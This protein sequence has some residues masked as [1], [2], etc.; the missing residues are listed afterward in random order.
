MLI[1]LIS[2]S[3]GLLE[4]SE[5]VQACNGITLAVNDDLYM[6]ELQRVYFSENVI[7]LVFVPL[8]YFMSSVFCIEPFKGKVKGICNPHFPD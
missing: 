3:L 5:P 6:S 1:V 7:S 4:P 2:G 8:T